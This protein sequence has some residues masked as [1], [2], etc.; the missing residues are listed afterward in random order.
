MTPAERPTAPPSS[1][2]AKE[3]A[4]MLS[5]RNMQ[6]HRKAPIV[7]TVRRRIP[8]CAD[9]ARRRFP[10]HRR[11]GERDEKFCVVS[12]PATMLKKKL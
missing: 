7:H 5:D 12:E 6:R 11:L 2:S 10:C 1:I 9:E 3:E 8:L 4:C